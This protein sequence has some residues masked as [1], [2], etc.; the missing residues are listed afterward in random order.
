[1]KL[2]ASIQLPPPPPFHLNLDIISSDPAAVFGE[3]WKFED[4]ER[5]INGLGDGVMSFGETLA[6]A[7]ALLTDKK[8]EALKL[9]FP[10]GLSEN[11]TII[12]GE[13]RLKALTE[14]FLA[15]PDLGWSMYKEEG[16]KTLKFL[17]DTFGVTWMEFPRRTLRDQDGL[18][19]SLCL[20]RRADGSWRCDYRWLGFERSASRPALGLAN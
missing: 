16:Q 1:M 2:T 15:D 8:D 3:G 7:I 12:T 20:C 11:Q 4:E 17:H 14:R 18:R 13:D 19:Y 6:K 10:T 9:L 5:V